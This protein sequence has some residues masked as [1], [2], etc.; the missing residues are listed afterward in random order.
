MATPRQAKQHKDQES[1]ARRQLDAVIVQQVMHALG[2][3][4]DLQSVQV[5][6]VWEN[7]YRVNVFTGAGVASAKV[8]N[9]YF[10]VADSAGNIVE[11]TP[12]I[13]KQY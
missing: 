6:Q 11:S 4:G 12:R 8:A 7:H 13:T 1:C 5:R 3:P 9:S 10:L 2:Q